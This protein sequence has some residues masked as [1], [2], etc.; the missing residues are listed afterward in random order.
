MVGRLLAS[1]SIFASSFAPTRSIRVVSSVRT[2]EWQTAYIAAAFEIG[3]PDFVRDALGVVARARGMA[4]ITKTA[5][6]NR[7]SLYK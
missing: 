3:D 1:P 7:E 5:K 6:L 4:G 2:P